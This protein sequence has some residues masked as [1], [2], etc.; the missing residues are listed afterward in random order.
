MVSSVADAEV[1]E[2]NESSSLRRSGRLIKPIPTRRTAAMKSKLTTTAGRNIS[3]RVD[4]SIGTKT[5]IITGLTGDHIPMADTPNFS[6]T[7]ATEATKTLN[8][9]GRNSAGRP[10]TAKSTSVA[11]QQHGSAASDEQLTH[12][13]TSDSDEEM[14]TVIDDA[15]DSD[16]VPEATLSKNVSSGHNPMGGALPDSPP[17]SDDASSSSKKRKADSSP[18]DIASSKKRSKSVKKSAKAKPEDEDQLIV[19][20]KGPAPHGNPSVWSE[21]SFIIFSF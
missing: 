11:V 1:V 3:A 15:H 12:S 17:A 18:S 4:L 7:T 14:S 2:V 13:D 21:V 20:P 8:S 9:A 10:I 19:R 6:E 5:L 16:F